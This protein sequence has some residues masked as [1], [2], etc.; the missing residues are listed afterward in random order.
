MDATAVL[1]GWARVVGHEWDSRT[2]R[3]GEHF[4]SRFELYPN[5]PMD[6]PD[7]AKWETQIFIKLRD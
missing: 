5:G 1:I 3:Q 7:S 2:D 4:A 6:E